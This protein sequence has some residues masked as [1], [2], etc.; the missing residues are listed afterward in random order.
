MRPGEY[1]I[2]Q[3]NMQYSLSLSLSCTLS[4][5]HAI[6]YAC[7]KVNMQYVKRG[8]W[9]LSF[10]LSLSLSCLF[11]RGGALTNARSI[12]ALLTLS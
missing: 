9:E 5:T 3:V 7:V 12:K 2:C 10:S 4:L 1:A 11:V 6:S 8:E